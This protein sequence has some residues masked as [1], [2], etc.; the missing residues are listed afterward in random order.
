MN[1]FDLRCL[2]IYLF[3]SNFATFLIWQS[4]ESLFGKKLKILCYVYYIYNY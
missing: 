2:F 3:I 1:I 4:M